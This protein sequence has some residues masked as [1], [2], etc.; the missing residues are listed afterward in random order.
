MA[1]KGIASIQL[2]RTVE[3]SS[4]VPQSKKGMWNPMTRPKILRADWLSISR[5]FRVGQLTNRELAR[6]YNVSESAIRKRALKEGWTR[7]LASE[8]RDQIDQQVRGGARNFLRAS[9]SDTQAVDTAVERGVQSVEGDLS[10]AARLK[11][12][13]TDLDDRLDR[14]LRGKMPEDEAR[15]LFAGKSDGI[16]NMARAL[17][18][19]VT[20]IQ[21]VE[22][23]ALS[24]DRKDD[25]DRDRPPDL[26]LDTGVHR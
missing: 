1:N 20:S 3:T 16:A 14:F 8:V 10:R 7:D 26:I 22:R 15:R 11:N 17:A 4:E 25:D 19:L 6:R 18:A 2:R 13:F 24:L 5:E 23:R 9:E 21:N 12:R